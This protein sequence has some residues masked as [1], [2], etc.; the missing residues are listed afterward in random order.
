MEGRERR[1]MRRGMDST[2]MSGIRLRQGRRMRCGRDV[3][4]VREEFKFFPSSSCAASLLHQRRERG[5]EG[6]MRIHG[7]N[8]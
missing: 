2:S 3:P 4:A 1:E 8:T 7:W 5:R 6:E